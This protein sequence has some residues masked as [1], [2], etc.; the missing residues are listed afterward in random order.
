MKH[1]II[2]NS[3][4]YF[5]GLDINFNEID[6]STSENDIMGLRGISLSFRLTQEPF[7]LELIPAT[8]DMAIRDYEISGLDLNNIESDKRATLGKQ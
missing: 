6:Y 1:F 4:L 5:T 3:L 2:A 7:R 8:V